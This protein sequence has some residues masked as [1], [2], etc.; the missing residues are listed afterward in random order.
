MF[1]L[2][3]SDMSD[4]APEG[5]LY[6]PLASSNSIFGLADKL[7]GFRGCNRR[8]V[9]DQLPAQGHQLPLEGPQLL[10]KIAKLPLVGLHN[11]F[12]HGLA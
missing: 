12:G 9:H 8:L 6:H 10:G 2:L 4:A 7:V 11:S 1:R 5:C 3:A